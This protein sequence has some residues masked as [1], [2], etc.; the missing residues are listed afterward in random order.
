MF[1][2]IWRKKWDYCTELLKIG[3]ST[4][5]IDL[6]KSISQRALYEFL[7]GKILDVLPDYQKEAEDHL[8]K[9]VKLNPSLADAWA[10]L[11]N[12][13]WKKGDLQSSKNCFSVALSMDPNKEI[14]CQLSMLERSM[15]QSMESQSHLV[16]ESI[17]HAKEAVTLDIKDGNSWYNLGNAYLT[18][19]FVTG[20]W[21]HTK[22]KQSLKAYKNAEKD[23]LMKLNPDLYFNC[24]MANKYLE[25]YERA[26]HG[27]EAAASKDPGLHAENEV[28]KIM[29]LLDKLENSLKWQDRSKRLAP[30]LASLGE[31][32]SIST[33]KKAN[34][35]ILT[36]GLN[37]AVMIVGIVLVS[38]MHDD[39][40]PSYYVLCDSN[41]SCFI[42]SVYGVHRE[43]IKEGD[44]VTLLDPFYRINALTWKQKHYEFNSIRVDF[45]EQILVNEKAPAARHAVRASINAQLKP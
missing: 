32:N 18:S 29:L 2:L 9:A 41:Q 22:L 3:T 14:L 12:C 17:Q 1:V 27:F 11:G 45:V 10:C 40:A 26:L 38:V 37:K 21:D 20:A 43:A 24:A 8:S 39:I 13:I 34:I 6:R 31:V 15:A 35:N 19:F 36:Q 28:H 4:S 23:E 5:V 33:H 16:D 25:N 42:L 44:R 7:R 30:L